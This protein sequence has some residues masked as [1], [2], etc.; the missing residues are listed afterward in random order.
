MKHPRWHAARF[1][2][3]FAIPLMLASALA[4]VGGSA[5]ASAAACTN[6]TGNPPPSPGSDFNLLQG[7]TVLS[8]CNA[9]AVGFQGDS[10][11]DLKTLIEHWNG[12]SWR[13]VASPDP[14]S[15][16]NILASV[17]A[18]SPTNIWAVGFYFDGAGDKTLIVRWN[19]HAWKKVSSPNPDSGFNQLTGM[20]VVS[21]TNAWA[22]GYDGNSAHKTLT[23]HWNGHAWRQVA[24]PN[25]GPDNF[26]SGVAATSG[27]DVWA[28]GNTV[29]SNAAS[30]TLILHWNGRRWR[31]VASPDPGSLNHLTGV[32]ATSPTNAWAVGYS[33]ESSVDERTLILH[34]NG[35][36]WSRLASP[37]LGGPATG[38]FLFGVT[39]TSAKNAWAVGVFGFDT[40]I[41][42]W[43]GARWAHVPSPTVDHDELEAVAA[44]S[45]SNAWAV[46][47]FT[48]PGVDAAVAVHCC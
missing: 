30:K 40:L 7:V 33:R 43:N 34:W 3:A 21:A 10:G 35:H 39:A 28:V 19:G 47:D 4:G 9:W 38:N 29:T 20:T 17:A 5:M 6:W 27:G 24:S 48:D 36:K 42:R 16:E 45:A 46:G 15:R 32:A 11:T 44:S 37:S 12:T 26:L 8:A 31:H 25:P 18:T 23:L 22:V 14:S 1:A 13:V 41:L 2:S